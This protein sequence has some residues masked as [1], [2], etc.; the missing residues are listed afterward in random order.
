MAKKQLEHELEDADLLFD[1][2]EED[3]ENIT[4]D[5]LEKMKKAYY[6]GE[7]IVS[8]E[9]YDEIIQQKFDG[10]DP[11]GYDVKASDGTRFEVKKHLIRMKGQD[12][13]LS[14]KEYQ[15][16]IEETDAHFEQ[17][18]EYLVQFKLDGLSLSLEYDQGQLVSALLRGN[19]AE[20]EE[21]ISNATL[22][23]GV[24]RLIPYKED[25]CFIRG[26]IV[27]T[28]EDFDKIP[29]EKKANRRNVAAGVSR[30]LDNELAHYLSFIAWGV[31]FP[32][33]E[34]DA[35]YDTES[36]RVTFLKEQGFE[37]VKTI[38]SNQLDEDLYLQYG[39]NRDKL[40]VLIDGLVIKM[41]DLKLKSTLRDNPDVQSGQVA[42]KF[43]AVRKSSII[44][45]V[46]WITGKTGKIA[47]TAIIEP[48]ELLG[49]VIERVTLCS[50]QEIE[51]L[52][53]QLNERVWVEKRGDVIPKI[54]PFDDEFASNDNQIPLTI[55]DRC[56][57]CNSRLKRNGADLFCSNP[58][59]P[60]QLGGRIESIFKLLDIKGF[61]E[62]VCDQLV[63]SGRVKS[64]PDIFKLQ[65][66]DLSIAC[67]YREENATN[68]VNRIKTRIDKGITIGEFIAILQI[69]NI[70][71]TTGE[72]LASAFDSIDEMVVAAQQG[73]TK[74]FISTVGEAAGLAVY[75]G[76]INM[77]HEIDD[78]LD[79]LQIVTV[80]KKD[81]SEYK[82]AFCFTG[83]RDKE[84]A[85]K[86]D[87][88]G[89]KELS[90]VTKQCTL[91][92]AKDISSGSGKLK[93]AEKQGCKVISLAQLIEMINAGTL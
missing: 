51:R 74:K 63:N 55:P 2:N 20:G 49:S 80:V 19:G 35:L 17:H 53:L 75:K 81:D 31:E 68:L 42:L 87:D 9:R 76:F 72:K 25:K 24:K 60:A 48:I 70:G 58:D 8:D 15:N 28:Q 34:E 33:K 30:R 18:L 23:K 62:I 84:L 46:D 43:P 73:E 11:L 27:L 89:Y 56:P 38:K 45:K 10:K 91:L 90:S 71:L 88:L 3:L 64:I 83:F 78:L 67:G 14:F 22:F 92:V 41:D 79:I 86:L 47:P 57:S 52:N 54:F 82:G 40:S 1:G 85:K 7:P 12:K 26:E 37:V 13:V 29:L 66:N 4:L 21:I 65:P 36:K 6:E 44:K 5:D 39:D 77:S 69:P 16:W 32:N 61:G 59:C 93:K 50:L